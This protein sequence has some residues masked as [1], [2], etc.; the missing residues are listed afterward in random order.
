MVVEVLPKPT[1]KKA[2]RQWASDTKNLMHANFPSNIRGGHIVYVKEAKEL[3]DRIVAM[4]T[5]IGQR[6]YS[7]GSDN[8]SY[9]GSGIGVGIGVGF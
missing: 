7:T 2:G 5:K 4:L 6:G 1:P 9:S 3:L 8:S